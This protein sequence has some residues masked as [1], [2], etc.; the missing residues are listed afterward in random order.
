M[1]SIYEKNNNLHQPVMLAEVLA[2]LQ[3]KQDGVYLDATFGRGGHAM[4][5]LQQLNDAGTLV[6]MD[7]D[8]EAIVAAEQC[9]AGDVRV[10]IIQG[11]YA[12]MAKHCMK[13]GI[14]QVDGVLLDLGVSSPQLDTAARGFSFKADGP[15]DMR[16]DPSERLSASHWLATA[17]EQKI[18]EVL[19]EYG[20]EKFARRIARAICKQRQQQPLKTT[21]QLADLVQACYPYTSKSYRH[22]AT[23]TFQAI[24]IYIN[25]ELTAL[26]QGLQASLNLLNTGG[27]LLILS[28][29]SLEDRIVKQFMIK[30]SR[31]LPPRYT[32][33][34]KLKPQDTEIACNARARSAILRI[35]EAC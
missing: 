14:K 31:A 33:V 6:V 1:N 34:H 9:F 18:A 24:R 16:F 3:I 5:I 13:L 17:S 19:R 27:R 25:G 23:K 29:H 28:F 8:P 15:L 32:K 7:R 22:P 21:K 12:E 11:S 2:E 30:H 20:E 35:A 4:A 26:E 10:Q